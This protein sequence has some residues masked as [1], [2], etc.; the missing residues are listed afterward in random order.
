[1]VW[2]TSRHAL[3]ALGLDELRRYELKDWESDKPSLELKA[4]HRLPDTEGHDLQPVPNSAKLTVTTQKHVFFF[5]REKAAFDPHPDLGDTVNLKCV[6]VQP[7]TGRT[8][9]VQAGGVDGKA[10]WSDAIKF[11]SPAETLPLN[12][13]KI[14]KVRWVPSPE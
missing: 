7:E 2:D 14:Y 3:W 11:L 6:N 9:Y 8:A 12:A 13:G 5:D 10:W 1:V 4:S